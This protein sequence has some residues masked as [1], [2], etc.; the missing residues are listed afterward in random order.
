MSQRLEVTQYQVSG[1]GVMAG[2]DLGF[3]QPLEG[4]CR[5]CGVPI[6][7]TGTVMVNVIN[8]DRT[9]TAMEM[10]EAD[11]RALVSKVGIAPPPI[12][13]G[14]HQWTENELRIPSG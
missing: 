2:A 7:L 12:L 4:P 11:A 3:A 10:T 5:D 13:C 9:E 8:E 14:R 1:I 6:D